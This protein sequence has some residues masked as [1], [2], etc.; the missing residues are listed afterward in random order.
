M[1]IGSDC[2]LLLL[3]ILYKDNAN[4]DQNHQACL[5]VMARC[6]LSYI[7]IMQIETR[8]IKLAWMLWRDA[9]LS[10]VKIMQRYSISSIN[11]NYPLEMIQQQKVI[12]QRGRKK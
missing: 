10:Y 12:R 1:F 11:T 8:T 6:S 2:F 9:A 7:K 5:D 4:R 3:L